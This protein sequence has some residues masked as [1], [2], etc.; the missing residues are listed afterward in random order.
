M[1]SWLGTSGQVDAVELLKQDQPLGCAAARKQLIEKATA[2][3]G[4]DHYYLILDDDC[5]F[6]YRSQIRKAASHIDTEPDIGIVSFPL[7]G[8]LG[9]GYSEALI[10]KHA[11]LVN[12]ALFRSGVNYTPGEHY[13]SA[14]LC[15]QSYL[16]GYRN[17]V[18]R[19]AFIWHDVN[20][21]NSV[22]E[23][24]KHRAEQSGNTNIYERYKDYI[25]RYAPPYWVTLNDKAQQLHNQ[26]NAAIINGTVNNGNIQ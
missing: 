15:I 4:Y 26:N 18:T 25:E 3:Y 1:L 13:D 9:W 19:E 5:R 16:A 23:Q 22:R 6:D 12:G 17:V 11:F 7:S 14:D 20:P 24:L 21:G 10:T 2:Q 8:I